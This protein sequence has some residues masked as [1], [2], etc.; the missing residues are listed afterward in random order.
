[1]SK[2]L[3]A[4]LC[5]IINFQ[6]VLLAQNKSLGVGVTAP[7]PNAALHVESPTANQG[8]IMPRLSTAQREAMTSLLTAGDKGLMLYDSDASTIFIWDGVTW[9]SSS[10]FTITDPASAQEGIVVSTVGSGAAGRFTVNN[11]STFSHAVFAENNGDSTSAAVHGNHTG[12]GFG[13]FGKSA[14]SKFA[15]AA[16]Y[17]E[18]VGT[19]DAAGAF[20]ISNASN[21]FSALFG[22]TNGSGP[23]VYGNQIGLGRGGQFQITNA[24][25][26]QAA[27][28]SYTAGTGYAGFY[29]INNPANASAGIYS[30]TN[31]TGPAVQAENTGTANGFAGLF[32]NTNATNNFPAIQASTQGS[33]SGVRVMQTTGIGAGMDVFMQNTAS[34]SPGFMVDSRG[35]G[36]AAVLTVSNAENSS[37]VLDAN[38]N[39]S[40]G[41]IRG[42]STGPGFAGWFEIS[43]TNSTA[44]ALSAS[45]NGTGTA[46][47]INHTG[48][49]GNIAVFQDSSLNVARI[50]KNGQGLFNGGT[51]LGGA[52]VA[53]MFDVEGERNSYEPGD[54]LVISEDTDR[55]VEKSDAPNSTLIAG[56]YA[57]K[58]GVKL[59]ERSLNENLDDLVPMGVIGVIPTKVCLENGPIK[60]GD[61]L[62]T[63]SKKGHAMKAIP[64]NI[65]GVLIY[66][67]GAIIGK[68]LENFDRRES[69]LIK[70]LVNVK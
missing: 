68:A 7:S 62:V 8:F 17:G 21:P 33:G 13:V 47:H 45:H 50:D 35:L 32:H 18:H 52:D 67:T 36:S 27:L 29:T 40:G 25:N 64:V 2:I 12:N 70:V 69:G 53:E 37:A 42:M 16:V 59:T 20:R 46:L 39:G 63:S 43:N 15:S 66:P 5:F 24:A 58:P 61:L 4:G 55:T 49:S 28:R 10:Q 22:E 1:M 60:R 48:S 56:V 3:L 34:N 44:A 54:V 51:A 26:S 14:G 9:E 23:A 65:N 38:T 6:S 57:T 19:G 31:G 11:A 41:A 30:V